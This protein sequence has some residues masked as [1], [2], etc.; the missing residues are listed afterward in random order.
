[1]KL[2]PDVPLLQ[3]APDLAVPLAILALALA[4]LTAIAAA[5]FL[6]L[7]ARRN[8]RYLRRVAEA[9]RQQAAGNLHHRAETQGP[10]EIRELQDSL[11]QMAEALAGRLQVLLEERDKLSSVLGTMAD[12]VV[13]IS[14]QGVVSMLNQAAREMLNLGDQKTEGRRLIEVARDHQIHHLISRCL[15]TGQSQSGRV[16]LL[17]PRRYLNAVASTLKS[18]GSPGM[19]LTLRDH[20]RARQMETSQREFVS[21]VSHELRNP[22]ASIKALVET[23]ED[24]AVE[25]R[26]V[27]LDLLRRIHHDVDRMDHMVN[28]L[29]E[30]SRL[31]SGQLSLRLNSLDLSAIAAEVKSRFDLTAQER[32]VALDLSL[33]PDLPRVLAD[34]DRVR[35]VLINLVENSMKFTP[36]HGRITLSARRKAPPASPAKGPTLPPYDAT[37][38]PG[39]L[40]NQGNGGFVEILVEDTGIGISPEDLAHIFERF[41]KADRSRHAGGTGLGLAIVKQIVEAHNGEVWARSQEG[42]G[43]TFGFT[44]PVAQ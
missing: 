32:R 30:L 8:S 35:Q 11:N 36:A 3:L 28:E 20:T 21:N 25:Q 2:P 39:P 18:N 10:P 26:E 31:E 23:L 44:L 5:T 13:V 17:R 1:M 34:E 16:E 37:I 29:L 7:R 41:Y 27:A 9:V 19:L 15:A 22:L 38:P 42:A 40:Y 43:S 12:G 24:G 33:P 4:G 14:P 6:Y